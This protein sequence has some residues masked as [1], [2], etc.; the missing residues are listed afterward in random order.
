MHIAINFIQGYNNKK[1]IGLKYGNADQKEGNTKALCYEKTT[2]FLNI[3]KEKQGSI[4]C[5]D[6]LG[7]DIGKEEGM[8]KAIETGIFM[9]ICPIMV[10]EA[11]ELLEAL[12]Y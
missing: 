12:D 9:K 1:T 3:F 6:L 4:V 11:V 2:E 5:K 7:C 8:A 10:R